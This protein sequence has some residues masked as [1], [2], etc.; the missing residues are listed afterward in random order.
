[1]NEFKDVPESVRDA[2][3]A[4]EERDHVG[5]PYAKFAAGTE[6]LAPEEM[7]EMEL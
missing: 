4:Y 6:H 1:L 3:A 5:T 2:A 7:L